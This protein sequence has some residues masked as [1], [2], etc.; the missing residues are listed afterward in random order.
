MPYARRML[1]EPVRTLAFGSI[2]AGYSAVGTALVN[3]ARLIFVQNLTNA[4]LMFSIDGISDHFP[5]TANGFLL[6]DISSDRAP[7]DPFFISAGTTLS[8]KQ[9]SVPT[10]GAVY[11]SVF[12]GL[13]DL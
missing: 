13:G 2:G 4:T 1:M 9:V 10:A 12:Y 6:L 7:V 3:P 11:F 8:V 5:L